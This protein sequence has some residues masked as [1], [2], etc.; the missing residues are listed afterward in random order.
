MDGKTSSNRPE[1]AAQHAPTPT[2][3]AKNEEA[4]NEL[5]PTPQL[6]SAASPETAP[7]LHKNAK[8]DV[9]RAEGTNPE[10]RASGRPDTMEGA[11]LDSG[12]PTASQIVLQNKLKQLDPEVAQLDWFVFETRIRSVIHDLLDAPVESVKGVKEKQDE[13]QAALDQARR[14]I[15]EHDFLLFKFQK[16]TEMEAEY[17][18]RITRMETAVNT[19]LTKTQASMTALDVKVEAAERKS[20]GTQESLERLNDRLDMYLQ[21]LKEDLD[22]MAARNLKLF[23]QFTDA[24]KQ[25]DQKYEQFHLKM[26]AHNSFFQENKERY[27]DCMDK[28]E[29][30]LTQQQI[31]DR[32]VDDHV[33][34]LRTEL[35]KL[36]KRINEKDSQSSDTLYQVVENSHKIG[37][38]F[39]KL[40]KVQ[41]RLTAERRY[42]LVVSPCK[43]ADQI[44]E[45]LFKATHGSQFNRILDFQPEF[46]KKLEQ[47]YDAYTDGEDD[48]ANDEE[49]GEDSEWLPLGFSIPTA[50]RRQPEDKL[51]RREGSLMSEH[52]RA[53]GNRNAGEDGSKGSIRK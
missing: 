41:G 30:M 20:T 23:T 45:V 29:G 21:K 27:Q 16:R 3:S 32:Y 46:Y 31:Q 7:R 51:Q 47:H 52:P 8:S 2:L 4:K 35:D 9:S 12:G 48:P 44:F 36:D 15:D 18:Q 13:L 34:R 49:R 1:G 22:K 42:Q 5:T 33:K 6:V 53:R 38:L 10:A 25:V 11:E 24:A 50:P 40:Q 26:E 19:Q 14:R 17:E 39:E 37:T 43:V 28:M